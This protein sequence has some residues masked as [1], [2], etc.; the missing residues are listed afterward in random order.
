MTVR[1]FAALVQHE[2]PLWSHIPGVVSQFTWDGK[3]PLNI[4]FMT[5]GSRGDHQPNIALGLE[6]A[7]RGHNVTVMGLEKYRHLIEQ[8]PSIHY[9]PLVDS[10]LWKLAHGSLVIHKVLTLSK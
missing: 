2:E 8:H 6:L 3:H 10:N 4:L 1:P 5:W 7:R 9:F